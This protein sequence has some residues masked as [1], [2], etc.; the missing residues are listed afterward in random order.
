MVPSEWLA[1][2]ADEGL[3]FL[4]PVARAIEGAVIVFVRRGQAERVRFYVTENRHVF[5][6]CGFGVVIAVKHGVDEAHWMRREGLA[7]LF[8]QG[9]VILDELMQ[10]VV[11]LA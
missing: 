4:D 1:S 8:E 3:S 2:S 11:D 9:G 7:K 6:S 5:G 10:E